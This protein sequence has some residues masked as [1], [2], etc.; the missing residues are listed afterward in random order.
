ML[1]SLTIVLTGCH[2]YQVS[3]KTV[4]YQR[5]H[6]YMSLCIYSS[7]IM[8]SHENTFH[9][10]QNTHN[11]CYVRKINQLSLGALTKFCCYS[12][13]Y[14]EWTVKLPTIW[15]SLMLIW[16]HCIHCKSFQALFQPEEYIFKIWVNTRS[17]Q[18]YRSGPC[19][20]IFF[21]CNSNSMEILCTSGARSSADTPCFPFL[22][23]F[24][25]L[26]LWIFLISILF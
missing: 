11:G 1:A 15:E 12:E 21:H 25:M 24:Y 4:R 19:F 26:C 22:Y 16:C 10:T 5:P 6:W 18:E 20:T 13:Q 7:M 9:I 14:I 2:G 3:P 23:F 8:S 17:I